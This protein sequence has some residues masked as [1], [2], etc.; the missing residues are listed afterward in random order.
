[1]ED[2]DITYQFGYALGELTAIV[3]KALPNLNNSGFLKRGRIVTL[4]ADQPSKIDPWLVELAKAERGVAPGIKKE[5]LIET[6][7]RYYKLLEQIDRKTYSTAKDQGFWFGYYHTCARGSIMVT[8]QRIGQRIRELRD[9][10]GLS[11]RDLENRT[12]LTHNH[13]SRIENGNYNVSLDT[14]SKIAAALD[15]DISLLDK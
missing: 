1:M 9:A 3:E 4:V 12:G 13:I 10:K 14:L 7:H 8:R 15:A 11:Q 5:D 6:L 2:K